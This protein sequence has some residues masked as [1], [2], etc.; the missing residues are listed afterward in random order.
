MTLRGTVTISDGVAEAVVVPELGAALASYDLIDRGKRKPLLRPCRDLADARPFDLASNLLLPWSNRIS[1]GGFYFAGAFHPLAPNLPGEPHPIHG[2]GF[3][4]AW[5]VEIVTARHID[6]TLTSNGPGPFRYEARASYALRAGALTMRLSIVNRGTDSL[7]FGLGFHPW[8]VRTKRALLQA[9]AKRVVLETSDH[10]PSG[11]ATI[12]SLP[13]FN[14]AKPRL[15]PKD[16]INNAFLGWD[17]EADIHWPDRKLAL[18]IKADPLLDVFI[19]HSPSQAADF[20]C[21]EPVTHRVDAH[22]APGGPE[23]NGLA[24]LA[25]RASLRATCRLEPRHIG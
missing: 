10:L 11:E 2:N 20:F 9:G 8:I 24:V 15:L 17:G 12:S 14:F 23:A 6:L 4:S 18:H 25:P 16:W 5:A 21:F 19:V 7:P 13:E 22:N 3:S 1:G